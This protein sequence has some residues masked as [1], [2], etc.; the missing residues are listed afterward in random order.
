MT[1]TALYFTYNGT[2]KYTTPGD[3]CDGNFNRGAFMSW[4]TGQESGAHSEMPQGGSSGGGGAT[5]SWGAST[6]GATGSDTGSGGPW[7][8]HTDPVDMALLVL[9][10]Y[11]RLQ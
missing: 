3:F 1:H 4:L 11:K 2:G 8:P 10:R 7:D 5:G 9:Q 6:P